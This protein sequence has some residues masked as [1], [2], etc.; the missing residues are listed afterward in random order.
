MKSNPNP[1]EE[2]TMNIGKRIKELKAE[3]AKLEAVKKLPRYTI[4]ANGVEFDM[5][6]V[7]AGDYVIGSPPD[8]PDR[9]S[10]EELR[11][12][13]LD[14]FCLGEAPVTQALWE[15]VMGDNPSHFT[16]DPRLPVESINL[17]DDVKE[18]VRRLS[19]M[20][21]Q[22]F[23]VPKEGQWEAACRAGT[24]TAYFWGDKFDPAYAHCNTSKTAPVKSKL[25]NQW[26]FYDMAGNVWE[27]TDSEYEQ[28]EAKE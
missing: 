10:D 18:F 25:P 15:A 5:I 17:A 3:I 24:D 6:E 12:V 4:N 28:T 19:A 7:P 27:W 16:G 11:T 20:T 2:K 9:F 13:A 26:G 8:E 1:R 21:G 23:Y 14:S 22:E